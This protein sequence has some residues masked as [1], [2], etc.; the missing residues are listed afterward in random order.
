MKNQNRSLELIISTVIC[1]VIIIL[2]AP[3]YN[4]FLHQIDP[5][6]QL[7][8]G[9]LILKGRHPYIH[10]LSSV[11]GPLVYYLS[12]LGQWLFPDRLTGELTLIFCGYTLAYFL[13]FLTF[14]REGGTRWT[15]FL[16]VLVGMASFPRFHKYY[17]LLGPAVMFYALHKASR[18]DGAGHVVFILAAASALTGFFR[19]DYGAYSVF[20]SILFLAARFRNRGPLTIAKMVTAYC[21]IGLALAAPWLVYL[22]WQGDFFEILKNVFA[23]SHGVMAGMA[24]ALPPYDFTRPSLNPSNRLFLTYWFLKL[25]PLVILACFAGE[26]WLGTR[27]KAPVKWRPQDYFL[28]TAAALSFLFYLQASHR[29]DISH[30]RQCAVPVMFVVLLYFSNLVTRRF[31]ER[32]ALRLCCNTA[33]T[34]VAVFLVISLHPPCLLKKRTYSPGNVSKKIASWNLT[35]QKAVETGAKRSRN[36]AFA[37]VLYRTR[38]LTGPDDAVLFTPFMPQ[39]YYFADRQFKPFFAWWHPGRFFMSG[40][41]ERYIESLEGTVL[42]VDQPEFDFDDSNALNA[43]TYA[44]KVIRYIYSNYGICQVVGPYVVLAGKP[45]IWQQYGRYDLGTILLSAPGQIIKAEK[46]GHQYVT[47]VNTLPADMIAPGE[48]ISLPHGAGLLLET[49]PVVPTGALLGLQGANRLYAVSRDGTPLAAGRIEKDQLIGTAGIPAGVYELVL[50]DGPIKNGDRQPTVIV[51]GWRI[52]L[53]PACDRE[54][55]NAGR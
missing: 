33:L 42:I 19:L 34:M 2:V 15:F 50:V 14:L 41:Q 3:S 49:A 27:R 24:K 45:V 17:I 11:Y 51:T 26:R 52:R 36:E 10:I 31:S 35:R 43:R 22:A 38:Q 23:A 48:A 55:D 9:M 21:C 12:A 30:V 5:G 4:S 46:D 29:I 8:K 53:V 16:F 1:A 25:A 7:T 47:S 32:L 54:T 39:A 37:K 6:D 40:S 28:A 44:P 18:S 13:L 20:C